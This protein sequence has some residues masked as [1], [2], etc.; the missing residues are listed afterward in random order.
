[1]YDYETEQYD[2][3]KAHLD[4]LCGQADAMRWSWREWMEEEVV[5]LGRRGG[6]LDA[7]TTG[8]EVNRQVVEDMDAVGRI[9]KTEMP[10]AFKRVTERIK[11]VKAGLYKEDMMTWQGHLQDCFG[12]VKDL[13]RQ[14]E[15]IR[16]RFDS[17]W[18]QNKSEDD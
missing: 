1:M 8:Q 3:D 11:E 17:L 14:L 15:E 5:A 13:A 6:V 9:T 7:L 12:A 18:G 2:R 4:L 16:G 10:N